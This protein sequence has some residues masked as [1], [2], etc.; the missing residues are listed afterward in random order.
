MLIKEDLSHHRHQAIDSI[1]VLFPAGLKHK[2]PQILHP[3][4]PKVS[5]MASC[6]AELFTALVSGALPPACLRRGGGAADLT[7]K[8][9]IQP[10]EPQRCRRLK[11]GETSQTSGRNLVKEAFLAICSFHPQ[12]WLQ[13]GSSNL[14]A[15]VEHL[16]PIL[17]ELA[18]FL[19]PRLQKHSPSFLMKPQVSAQDL[20]RAR[21]R[22]D[23]KDKDDG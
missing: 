10:S 12:L 22:R 17:L 18:L 4:A 5:D 21:S 15:S 2:T 9:A 19:E 3:R 14:Q 7:E 11:S 23:A 20:H 8:L 1:P 6:L 13:Q 16:L